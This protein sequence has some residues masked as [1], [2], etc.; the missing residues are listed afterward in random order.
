VILATPLLEKINRAY[1]DAWID[2]LLKTGMEELF[3]D[4]PYI[5]AIF[6][7]DKSQNKYG[8]LLRLI[9]KVRKN[10][11]DSVINIQ[12]FGSTGIITALSNAGSTTGFNKN[13]FSFL[14]T[15]RVSHEIGT[16]VHEVRRNLKLVTEIPGPEIPRPVL[17]P[18]KND[19]GKVS[20]FKRGIYYTISPTSL[21]FTKQFPAEKW[22]EL[23]KVVPGDRTVY[24]L[25]SSKDRSCCDEIIR[26]S[27]HP[28]VFSLAGKLSLLESAALMKNARMNFTND[29]APLH[30]AS[31]VNAPSTA[32]FCSTVPAFGFGPLSDDSMVI[33][34]KEELSCRPCGLH[35]FPACPEKHFRCALTIP[36]EHLKARL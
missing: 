29:S 16:G 34:T 27:G 10:A 26:N 2:L 14:F 20:V 25:G 12:R 32:V 9:R 1:P 28:G 7:L 31:A 17:Y 30:L 15:H 22:T 36:A 23:V 6:L 33:E 4:H 19:F 35:G 3:R 8:N 13:P 5:H 11:Y 24:L 18:S 21:W